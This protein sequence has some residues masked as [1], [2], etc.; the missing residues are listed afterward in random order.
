[1]AD[2]HK[3]IRLGAAQ[4]A[5]CYLD[6]E[7]TIEKDVEY[8]RRAGGLGLDLLVFP[9]F[10]VPSSPYWYKVDNTRDREEYYKDLFDN[11]VMIPGPSI[12]RICEAAAEAGTAVVLGV[13][14]KPSKKAG[15]LYNTQ[16]FVDSDGTLLGSRRKLVPT[17]DERLFHTGGTGEDMRVFDSDIGTLGGLMCGEHGNPLAIYANLALGEEIH[18]ASWTAFCPPVISDEWCDLRE[19]HVGIRTRYHALSG[20][21]PVAA[22][23]GVMTEDLAQ[24]IGHPDLQP[25]GGLSFITDTLGKYLEGPIYEGEQI[26]HGEIDMGDRVRGKATHDILGH[27]NR[28]DI[29]DV[30]IDKSSHEP[31]HVNNE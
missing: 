9:E 2:T 4:V 21:V 14:E 19:E 22:A 26:V 29:F 12:D 15:S 7:A 13:N 16:V 23:S 30:S 24:S 27:Y 10:H 18:A 17:I 3:T 31:I 1:M 20:R 5:E 11:A 8:I 28:F 25:G 6:R